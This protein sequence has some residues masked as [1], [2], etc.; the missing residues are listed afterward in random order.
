MPSE[1][2]DYGSMVLQWK[3]AMVVGGAI[4]IGGFIALLIGSWV[5]S[6]V[7]LVGGIALVVFAL[8]NIRELWAKHD[9]HYAALREKY[10]R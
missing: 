3:G 6:S 9:A 7:A 5:V 1:V 8:R 4:I 2:I 10:G